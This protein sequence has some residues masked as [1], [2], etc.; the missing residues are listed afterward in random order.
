MLLVVAH[1]VEMA[2]RFERSY[3]AAIAAVV[4]AVVS[5]GAVRGVFAQIVDDCSRCGN[6]LRVRVKAE[7]GQLGYAELFAPD[8]LGVVVLKDP[9]FQARFDTAGAIEE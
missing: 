9:V 8:A 5:I 1:A 4:L 7:A 2:E 6:G 3:G